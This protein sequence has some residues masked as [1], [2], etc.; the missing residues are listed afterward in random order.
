MKMGKKSVP[1]GRRFE[2]SLPRQRGAALLIFS[3]IIVMAALA[4]LVSSLAPD[5][6]EARRERKSQEALAQAREA[7][8]GYALRYRDDQVAK[9]LNSDGDDDRVMYGYL[10]L[11]DLGSSR[12][13][14]I[15]CGQE[16]CDAN[17]FTGIA[18]DVN[19]IGPSVIGRLPWRT[20]GIEPLRDGRGECLWLIV[21]SLHS[22]IQRSAPPPVL[23]PMNWDTLGQL[24]IF[25]ANGGPALISA[26]ANAHERPVAI[27]FSP[28]PP[29]PGQNRGDLGGNDVTQ[30]GGNYEAKNY[31][32]PTTATA[33][34]DVTNY[35]AGDKNA[36]GTTGDSDPSNDPDTPKK[37]STQGKVFSS[38]GNFLPN[39]CQGA[40]CVLLAN[41]KGLA[42]TSDT[43]FGAIRKN[44]YFRTDINSMLDRMTNCLRDK[45][46]AGGGFAPAAISG[47]TPPADKSA[48]RIPSDTCYDSTQAPLGY[49]DHYQEMTFVAKPN[50]GN[51][52]VNDDT[53]CAGVLV[54]AG[55]RDKTTLRCPPP[56]AAPT[57]FQKRI[58]SGIGGDKNNLCN[59]LEG[60]N[61]FS[62]T[63][64]GTAF[65]SVGGAILFD[66][67][68][69]LTVEQDNARCIPASAS[70]TPVTS[71]ILGVNPLVA[72]DAVTRTLTLGRVGIES[73]LGYP[74]AVLYGCAWLADVR[75]LGSGLRTYFRFQF[76][77]LGTNVGS[78]G[79]VFAIA[80]ALKNGFLSCG[81][82]GTHLG[83]S[84]YNGV[85]SK[86]ASP[87]IGIEFDQ[88]RN[89]VLP[90]GFSENVD[91][92]LS[93]RKDPCGT[94]PS[95]LP[96]PDCAPPYVGYNSHAA[97]VYWG[98][99]APN[100]ADG[101]TQPDF[102]DNVHGF[103]SAGSLPGA[104]RPAP[105]SHV[106]PVAETGIKFVNMR[107]FDPVS[108]NTDNDYDSR[109]F[110]VRIEMT[111]VPFLQ[112][113]AVRVAAGANVN[114]ASPGA[115]IDGIN[116]SVGNRVLLNAQTSAADNGV[117]IWN[118]PTNPMTRSTDAD[119]GAELTQASVSVIEGTYA[120][121]D[122][123]QTLAVVAVDV[124]LQNWQSF[125]KR[126]Q[127]LVW[128]EGDASLTDQIAA[129]KN[130]TRPMSLL[131]P[132][133]ASTLSDTAT[134]FYVA[135]GSCPCASGQTCGTDNLCYRPPLQKLQLGFTGSQRTQDQ[136]VTINDFFTTWLP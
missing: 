90:N 22:R 77:K 26:L 48:G 15:G 61:L 4:Y 89:Y 24:D 44:A 76:K 14:N 62:F 34:V 10:P 80:D 54:F 105:R 5:L 32:D 130:T 86:I 55:Q 65:G 30:C 132:G 56:P 114:L 107:G 60:S 67:S 59:Y 43:L 131:Y 16:G 45:F 106:N 53:N 83:Y 129:L 18:F 52:T 17:T 49:F 109:I 72:Y 100:G 84:G 101:V 66:S 51:F 134:M 128:I 2:G 75:T 36:S 119:S 115:V 70:F 58:T 29:L 41:D 94:T 27:V 117:Y 135:E 19:G 39:A 28:G 93:G 6:S 79:F 1:A 23:P 127:T 102:D 97:I 31:L 3:I 64:A 95:G 108:G 25:V 42:L 81:A 20:L 38:G 136:E 37:F 74:A 88:G 113:A 118:G 87:K 92:T 85:T 82:A 112:L 111:E 104:T 98:H 96:P 133:Y 12:N 40:D 11:P 7:L 126:F 120:G 125:V 35:L 73:D 9:D 21:S 123:R 116:L 110:H 33:L 124:D 68:P 57:E 47:F 91:P 121:L 13:Q 69:P 63:G 50:S 122:L 8:I 99:E 78:N 71:P 46:I 103:P